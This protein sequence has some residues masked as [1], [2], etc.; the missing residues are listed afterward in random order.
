MLTQF[1]R[2]QLV[3]FAVA[4]VIAMAVMAV[5]YMQIPTLLGVGRMTV[6]LKLPATGGLY[7]F[8]NVTYRGAQVGKVT[9]I[10]LAAGGDAQ[11][12][13][14]L[15]SSAKI[16]ADLAADVRS[17]SAIG[18]QYVDLRPRTDSPPYLHNGSV[19][20]TRDATIPQ[21]VGPML[22]QLTAL[23]KSIPKDRLNELLD[24]SFNGLNGA[25]NDLGSL[26]DSSA[27]LS[28]DVNSVRD[29]ARTLIDDS[30]PLLDSQ[31]ESVDALRQWT[32]SLAAVT[33]QVANDD[34]PLRTLLNSGPGF[35]R[36]TTR[37]LDQVKPT[38]PVL[39]A[40]LTTIGKIGVTY[41]PSLEQLL[42]L[43]PPYLAAQ[44]S[45]GLPENN[46]TGIALSDFSMTIGDPPAC[47]V[48]YLPPSSWRSPADTTTIDTPDGLYCKLPQ[49]SPIAVRG[50]RNY[51]CMD[52]PGKRAPTVQQCESDQP[53]APVAMR[54]HILGPYP[55]DPNLISQGVPPDDRVTFGDNIFAPVEGTP[56]PPQQNPQDSAQTAE[57]AQS[58]PAAPSA[59]PAPAGD[60]EPAAPSAFATTPSAAAPAVAFA[61]YNPRTG[62]Y[63]GTD[64]QLYRQTD[65]VTT[66]TQKSWKDLVFRQE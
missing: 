18:E 20:A 31:A 62:S 48:G 40:N 59:L 60:A 13:L 19:I 46:P 17:V 21:K 57:P 7:R 58:G 55:M 26:I 54:Q 35:A 63:T 32:H 27:T 1:V 5:S 66:D 42:V 9:A 3:I 64:G 47:T 36:E 25:G 29:R 51:P 8:A 56:P 45:Y 28:A 4:G 53:Y 61:R 6:T 11:A 14:S 38:L 15:N 37:L 30:Q 10:D 2:I 41:N 49:D 24:E 23:T 33:H 50:A 34:A 52:V 22:D 65:L 43:L 16:P 39:L 12:T 44:Q